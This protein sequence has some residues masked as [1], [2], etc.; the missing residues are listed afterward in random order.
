LA[1]KLNARNFQ[2]KADLPHILSVASSLSMIELQ[3]KNDKGNPASV[4]IIMRIKPVLLSAYLI[5]FPRI[6]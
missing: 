2:Q 1:Q 3:R 6:G 5:L 4:H